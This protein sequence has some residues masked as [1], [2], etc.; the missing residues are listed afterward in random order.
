MLDLKKLQNGSSLEFAAA[1]VR[2]GRPVMVGKDLSG[3]VA[4]WVEG[5]ADRAFM[6][7]AEA[8]RLAQVLLAQIGM[9][10]PDIEGL[11]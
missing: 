1:N 11:V 4:V 8:F 3:T 7:P 9:E 2:H 10:L 5:S 6:R